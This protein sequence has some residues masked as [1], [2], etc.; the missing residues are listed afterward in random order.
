MFAID[1]MNRSAFARQCGIVLVLLSF[2]AVSACSRSAKVRF[3]L[4][5]SVVSACTQPVATT[6]DWD[7]SGLGL[8][9]VLIE[10]N[11]LGRQPKLWISGGPK[12]SASAGAWAH[13]GYSVTL[14]AKNGVVIAKRTLTTLPC[15]GMS[16]L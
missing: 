15:P 10:V 7:V 6:V 13:D 9:F 4:Q 5:P 3:E 8:Q 1:R 12:G 16:W 2:V 11:N 14:K